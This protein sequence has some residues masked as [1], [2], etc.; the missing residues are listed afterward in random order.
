MSLVEDLAYFIWFLL[1]AFLLSYGAKAVAKVRLWDLGTRG[2][3]GRLDR[4][5]SSCMALGASL[6][7]FNRERLGFFALI[8]ILTVVLCYVYSRALAKPPLELETQPLTGEAAERLR[9]LG[10]RHPLTANRAFFPEYL[11]VEYGSPDELL[12]WLDK[13]AALVIPKGFA[14]V[15]S[16]AEIDALG[17]R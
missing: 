14:E 4:L 1:W 6:C 12:G 17:A 16:Q 10:A 5:D 11:I 13:R 2:K 3:I 7:L 9:E 8:A 15:A